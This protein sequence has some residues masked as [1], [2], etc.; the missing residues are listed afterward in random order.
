MAPFDPV[1]AM[2]RER[3]N[4]SLVK[5][6]ARESELLDAGVAEIKRLNDCVFQEHRNIQ[7]RLQNVSMFAKDISKLSLLPQEL[8][9]ELDYLLTCE[10]PADLILDC[11]ADDKENQQCNSPQKASS[12]LARMKQFGEALKKMFDPCS[13]LT[14]Q[15]ARAQQRRS[16]GGPENEPEPTEVELMEQLL[17]MLE[18]RTAGD[19]AGA[20]N[21]CCGSVE[22]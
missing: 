6:K 20:A 19:A 5:L 15:A 10:V 1:L 18:Q 11:G 13:E 12:Y 9:D 17:E 16:T 21:S 22:C 3:E 8:Q 4:V 2:A 14:Q 7:I